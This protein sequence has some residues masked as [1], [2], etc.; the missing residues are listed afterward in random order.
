MYGVTILDPSRCGRCGSARRQR[1]RRP[2]SVA[3]RRGGGAARAACA[4]SAPPS[5]S[6]PAPLAPGGG[7]AAEGAT[8]EPDT[9]LAQRPALS[10]SVLSA[11]SFSVQV[12]AGLSHSA[13][14]DR[15]LEP[16][17]L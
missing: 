11:A 16:D 3:K 5:P 17:R 6:R 12:I 10:S 8:S 9:R 13:A 4:T 14:S 15:P 7:R 2:R 1:R